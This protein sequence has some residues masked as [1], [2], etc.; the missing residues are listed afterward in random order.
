M[1]ISF[2]GATGTA[3][4]SVLANTNAERIAVLKIIMVIVWWVKGRFI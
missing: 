4:P 2:S 3:F 1:T